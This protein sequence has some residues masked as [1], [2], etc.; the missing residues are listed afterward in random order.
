MEPLDRGLGLSGSGGEPESTADA[1]PQADQG[2]D[3]NHVAEEDDLGKV[4]RLMSK[5]RRAEAKKTHKDIAMLVISMLQ[6]GHQHR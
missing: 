3:I 1:Q 5:L 6:D 4:V 2:M